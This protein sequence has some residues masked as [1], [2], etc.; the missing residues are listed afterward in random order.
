VK[1][2]AGAA[3]QFIASTSNSYD[4]AGS[5]ITP[6][7]GIGQLTSIGDLLLNG[8]LTDNLNDANVFYSSDQGSFTPSLA[9]GGGAVGITYSIQQGRYQ[10][11]GSTVSFTIHIRLTSAGSSVGSAFINNL[12]YR[13][14]SSMRQS[15]SINQVLG[16][17]G[18]TSMAGYIDA[19]DNNITLINGNVNSTTNL[20]DTNISNTGIFLIAGTY[21][22]A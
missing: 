12:P 9:F 10:K 5:K 1:V 15:V 6:I 18:V 16:V 4:G 13:N 8:T 3:A 22:V 17:S 7:T 19:G 21:M 11:L 20:N 14:N 2:N